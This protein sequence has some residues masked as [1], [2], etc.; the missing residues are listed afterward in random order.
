MFFKIREVNFYFFII[1]WYFLLVI[2]KIEIVFFVLL[3]FGFVFLFYFFMF[4]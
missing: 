2:K 3:G 4:I 1:D